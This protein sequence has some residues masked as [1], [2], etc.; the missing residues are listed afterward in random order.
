MNA[1]VDSDGKA[2]P[3]YNWSVSGTG[4]H[5][6][7]ASGPTAATTNADLETLQ[8]WADDTAC[9]TATITVTDNCEGTDTDYVRCTTG[10]EKFLCHVGI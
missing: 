7:S 6:N 10:T 5:F 2:C 8:L 4:F 9:G 1:W 3:P